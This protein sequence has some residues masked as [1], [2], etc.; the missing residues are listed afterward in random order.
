LQDASSF[1]VSSLV[2]E[3]PGKHIDDYKMYSLLDYIYFDSLV[4]GDLS[5]SVVYL[6]TT[7]HKANIGAYLLQS[8][9]IV[10]DKKTK[11][12]ETI[13]ECTAIMRVN[14]DDKITNYDSDMS[15]VWNYDGATNKTWFTVCFSDKLSS[16]KLSYI[17]DAFK[18]RTDFL[19]HK[20]SI[21]FS[22]EGCMGK[23]N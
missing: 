11:T 9:E 13:Q 14:T 15:A 18:T 4:V 5:F 21:V 1:T 23:I 10:L 16:D 17:E 22:V 20:Y 6:N 8:R 2:N 19:N 7:H 12:N 3:V